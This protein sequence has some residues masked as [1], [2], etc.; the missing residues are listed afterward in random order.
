MRREKALTSIAFVLLFLSASVA[1]PII[2][3]ASGDGK[4]DKQATWSSAF[5][6]A[7]AEATR[8]ANPYEGKAEAA[9]AGQKL[10]KR[11]CEECHGTEGAGTNYAPSLRSSLLR[12]AKPGTLFWFLKNGNL[13][14]GMP[15]WSGLP[16]QQRW[17]IV[18]Y[19]KSVNTDK[20]N[21][22]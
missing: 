10:F 18:S 4:K 14:R 8:A 17:Q 20:E 21:E 19:L 7:P 11:H 13:R 6:R 9:L 12:A 15:S 1:V 3:A 2:G 5:D 22:R 16:E